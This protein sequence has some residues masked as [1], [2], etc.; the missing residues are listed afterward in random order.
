MQL[1]DIRS[2]LSVISHWSSRL[3]PALLER[4]LKLATPEALLVYSAKNHEAAY[5]G[6]SAIIRVVVTATV[7]ERPNG[8][9]FTPDAN[10]L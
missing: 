10:A 1:Y 9:G 5:V 7:A 3:Q 2:D 6:L 4:K 8:K